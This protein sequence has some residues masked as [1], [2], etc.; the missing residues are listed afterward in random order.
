MPSPPGGLGTHSGPQNTTVLRGRIQG[1]LARAPQLKPWHQQ[2]CLFGIA[3]AP[4]GGPPGIQ[5]ANFWAPPLP[6][7]PPRPPHLLASGG[8]RFPEISQ[9]D[10]IAFGCR[11]V[12]SE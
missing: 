7:A 1:Y 9:L 8:T 2:W 10:L 4:V 11:R 6:G 5:G 3:L 12:N